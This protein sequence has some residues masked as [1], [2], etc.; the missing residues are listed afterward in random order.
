MENIGFCTDFN[1]NFEEAISHVEP[2]EVDEPAPASLTTEED[3]LGE[4][5]GGEHLD[6][7]PSAPAIETSPRNDSSPE[8]TPGD[9]ASESV[10]SADSPMSALCADNKDPED[11]D[12]LEEYCTPKNA[13]VPEAGPTADAVASVDLPSAATS[14]QTSVADHPK[15]SHVSKANTL[16]AAIR[17]AMS[18][19]SA[20]A[21]TETKNENEDK[22]AFP[23]NLLPA[24]IGKI[25]SALYQTRL[26]PIGYTAMAILFV[27]SILIG[28]GACL[29]TNLGKT[30]ANLYIAFVGPTGEDKTRPISWATNPLVPM[31]RE[32]LAR[33]RREREEYDAAVAG[34]AKGLVPPDYPRRFLMSDATDEA[35][36]KQLSRCPE[37]TG[38]RRDELMDLLKQSAK[39]SNTSS[40]LYL[41]LYSGANLEVDRATKDEVYFIDHPFVSLIGGIQ[42]DR[43][44]KAFRGDRMDSG[45]F[46]RM[47]L[48]VKNGYT[49][50]L[51]DLETPIHPEDIDEQ[52]SVLLQKFIETAGWQGEYTL[53]ADAKSFLTNW[54]NEEES[55]LAKDGSDLKY[56]V[57]R[58]VQVYALKFA[59]ILQVV[60]DIDTAT[61]NPDHVIS[62]QNAILAASLADYFYDV[63]AAMAEEIKPAMLNKNEA[64]LL[65]ALPDVFTAKDG[66]EHAKKYAIGKTTFYSFLGK[67]TGKL[68]E[69]TG[70]GTYIKKYSCRK[71]STTAPPS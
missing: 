43:F 65:E 15:G 60:G 63:S 24:V 46:G 53:D 3:T 52:Y 29:V 71:R 37:S 70:R 13:V 58:K 11:D 62:V 41:S 34:G 67:L 48:V 30:M 31:D 64:K 59:L 51:W 49:Q 54:Q 12:L 22:D 5:K 35:L 33:Y 16:K 20:S 1:K 44:I 4:G 42:P 50:K 8:E 9:S 66:L 55:R 28:K 38:L 27:I 26:F 19:V 47:L 32:S 2:W 39:Y 36:L 61:P 45:L 40:D 6:A 17:N 56:G 25:A 68:I 69:K 23:I 10:E 57:F 7:T 21:H 18:A 14:A